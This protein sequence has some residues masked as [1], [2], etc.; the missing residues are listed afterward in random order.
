MAC[1]RKTTT[2]TPANVELAGCVGF[3]ILVQVGYIAP[4]VA[5]QIRVISV[6]FLIDAPDG[7]IKKAANLAA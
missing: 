7:R 5:T 2:T 3:Y 1:Y 4:K 6:R